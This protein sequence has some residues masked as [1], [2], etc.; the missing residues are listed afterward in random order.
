[1]IILVGALLLIAGSTMSAHLISAYSL[2]ILESSLL[3]SLHAPGFMAVAVLVLLIIRSNTQARRPYLLAALFCLV[4]AVSSE[5]SQVV[6]ARDADP[7]DLVAD[8]LGIAAGLLLTGH[9]FGDLHRSDSRTWARPASFAVTILLCSISSFPTLDALYAI[10]AQR[11]AM[12]N[13]A[14]FETRWEQR[15]YAGSLGRGLGIVTSPDNSFGPG[16]RTALVDIGSNRIPGLELFPFPDWRDFEY[17]SFT[18]GSATMEPQSGILRI[19]DFA[20]KNIYE[21]RFNYRF[22]VPVEPVTIRIP[23]TEIQSAPVGRKIDL[24]RVQAMIFFS[25]TDGEA[26]IYIDNIRLE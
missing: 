7:A 4:L 18:T 24:G 17:L 16:Q 15:L 14:T 1:M 6:M 13:L 20:H 5:A 21:D 10:S 11:S 25:N 19:H 12:P 3:D 23:L 2:S 8:I 9:Y 26:R 22:E